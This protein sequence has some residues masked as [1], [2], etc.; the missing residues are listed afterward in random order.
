VLQQ[1]GLETIYRGLAL[2]WSRFGGGVGQ[3]VMGCTRG[4]MLLW[5]AGVVVLQR[6][7]VVTGQEETKE[8]PAM[9]DDFCPLLVKVKSTMRLSH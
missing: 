5:C 1:L 9:E 2:V 4:G 6:V 3:P 7:L 8:D